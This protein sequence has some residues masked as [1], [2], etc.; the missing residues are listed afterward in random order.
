M[1]E[2]DLTVIRDFLIALL[3]GALVGIEREKSKAVKGD[4]TF[5]GLRTFILIAALGA[6]A[7]WFAAPHQALWFVA[8]ALAVMAV[9]AL[10][11]VVL[12]R[13]KRFLGATRR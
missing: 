13:R 11:L 5:G 7:G 12:F 9:V 10:S 3:I 8:I 1:N 2:L 6:L 4:F